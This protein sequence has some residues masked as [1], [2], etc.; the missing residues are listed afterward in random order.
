MFHFILGAV[1]GFV[2]GCFVPALGRKV[3]ALF[4]KES[5]VVAAKVESKL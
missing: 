4:S 3:K 2:A 5:K 1:V